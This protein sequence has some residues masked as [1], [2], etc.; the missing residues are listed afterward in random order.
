MGISPRQGSHQV[1]QKFTSNTFPL[2]PESATLF[3]CKSLN[4]TFGSSASALGW[5]LPPEEA[6]PLQP[7]KP[8]VPIKQSATGNNSLT[9]LLIQ[10]L[11]R[12]FAN[13]F[14]NDKC[15]ESHVRRLTKISAPMNSKSAPLKTSTVCKCL[16]KRW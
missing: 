3:P 14:K 9:T 7:E 15:C 12:Y 16:R 6:P 4:V 1:P 8:T 2:K 10:M 11:S 13:R 5:V